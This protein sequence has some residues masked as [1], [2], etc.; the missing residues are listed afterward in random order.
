[1]KQEEVSSRQSIQVLSHIYNIVPTKVV[2]TSHITA[3]SYP[4]NSRE[5]FNDFKVAQTQQH[6]WMFRIGLRNTFNNASS[7]SNKSQFKKCWTN[8][9]HT[10]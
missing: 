6:C 7:G 8:N 5:V 4:S 10:S 3:E 9:Y 2:T 1:M